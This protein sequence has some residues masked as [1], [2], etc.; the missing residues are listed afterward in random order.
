M[1]AI[2][3]EVVGEVPDQA[4]YALLDEAG[5]RGEGVELV[6]EPLGMNP[7]CVRA[8]PEKENGM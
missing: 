3:L 7:A 8:S 1:S 2:G 4:S 6:H 5:L